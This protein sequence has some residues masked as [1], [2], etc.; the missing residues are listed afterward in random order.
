MWKH[1]VESNRPQMIIWRMRI[2]C[3]VPKGTNTQSEYVILIALPL[4]QWL[5]ERASM[6]RYMRT[7]LTI[8]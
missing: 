3:W 4:P 8:Y 6:L 2:A 5:Y 7:V 1:I